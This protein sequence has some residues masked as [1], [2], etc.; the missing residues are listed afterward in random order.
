M[1]GRVCNESSVLGV[2]FSR[3]LLSCAA[4]RLRGHACPPIPLSC[5][6]FFAWASLDLFPVVGS[7]AIFVCLSLPRGFPGWSPVYLWVETPLIYLIHLYGLIYCFQLYGC[8]IMRIHTNINYSSP[9]WDE[10]WA[11][12]THSSSH[13]WPRNRWAAQLRRNSDHR[14]LTK[15]S[16]DDLI[17]S[18]SIPDRR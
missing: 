7:K 2:S 5:C 10:I 12:V 8:R 4:Q 11:L 16:Y 15:V 17:I 14:T 9:T 1:T 18:L 6:P 13:A 3:L